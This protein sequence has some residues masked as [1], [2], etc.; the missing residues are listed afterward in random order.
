VDK[1]I[2]PTMP[3]GYLKEQK[4]EKEGIN[5]ASWLPAWTKVGK[6]GFQYS[7]LVT[8]MNKSWKKR[9]PIWPL[10]YLNEQK[11]EKE[12]SNKTSW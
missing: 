5:K 3:L 6:R 4:V 12:G 1:R 7:P 10:G 9:V 8:C 11:V 2:P